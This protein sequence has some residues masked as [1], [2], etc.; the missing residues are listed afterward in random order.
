MSTRTDL[1]FRAPTVCRLA[2]ISYRQLD[3]WDRTSIVS[4]SIASAR[5]SGSQRLYAYADV[6]LLMVVKQLL[7]AGMGMSTIRNAIEALR[8]L[9]DAEDYGALVLIADHGWKVEVAVT[10][11]EV[12]NT[13]LSDPKGRFLFSI[14]AMADELND[15]LALFG[16]PIEPSWAS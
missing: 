6:L 8:P 10:P 1:G 13:V 12:I 11:N 7:N 3:Y 16:D 2:Q 5:G 14:Q 4:P 15:S 9:V